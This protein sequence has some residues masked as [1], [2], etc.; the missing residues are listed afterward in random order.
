[1]HNR[2]CAVHLI[3]QQN[4]QVGG[5]IRKNALFSGN[6]LSGYELD[7]LQVGE[8]QDGKRSVGSEPEVGSGSFFGEGAAAERQ[9]A[10]AEHQYADE[11]R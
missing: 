2:V 6:D 5:R 7:I 1:M 8:D 3:A 4:D 10:N 9:Q 11:N